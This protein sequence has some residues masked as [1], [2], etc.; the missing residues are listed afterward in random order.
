MND[1]QEEF[2]YFTLNDTTEC[3][4]M[5]G[6]Q[7]FRLRVKKDYP[8]LFEVLSQGFTESIDYEE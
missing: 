2:F 1:K 3:L 6:P 8:E 5:L 4:H 7:E